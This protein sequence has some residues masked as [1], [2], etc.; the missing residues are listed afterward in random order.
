MSAIRLSHP[1]KPIR[2]IVERDPWLDLTPH[3]E[4]V[5]RAVL[6]RR[7]HQTYA[8]HD[9]GVTPTA[10]ALAVRRIRA[11]GV[12]LPDSPRRGPDLRPRKGKPTPCGQPMPRSRTS[13]GRG[14]GHAGA[15]RTIDAIAREAV[16]QSRYERTGRRAA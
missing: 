10:V 1:G 15:H 5:A 14:A 4:R 16:K 6:A 11:V 3:Q 12:R 13:C 8:A 7:G 9:L 2:L